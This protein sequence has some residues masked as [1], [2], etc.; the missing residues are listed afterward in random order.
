MDGEGDFKGEG[1]EVVVLDYLQLM[2]RERHFM[3]GTIG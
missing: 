1:E 3:L 2:E